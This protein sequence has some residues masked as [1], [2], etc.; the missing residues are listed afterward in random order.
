[1][2]IYIFLLFVWHLVIFARY[3]YNEMLRDR[4]KAER[5]A[6]NGGRSSSKSDLFARSNSDV[7]LGSSSDLNNGSP[8]SPRHDSAS[9]V[10]VPPMSP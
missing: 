1:M 9:T 8:P 6:A 2:V 4:L 7:E 10:E 3:K 5:F